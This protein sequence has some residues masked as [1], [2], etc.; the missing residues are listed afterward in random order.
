MTYGAIAL[1]RLLPTSQARL[2]EAAAAGKVQGGVEP[3][4][5]SRAAASLRTLGRDIGP[6]HARRMVAPLSAGYAVARSR[7]S[8]MDGL[9][10][11]MPT[12]RRL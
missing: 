4:D 6:D 12:H 5:L 11:V 2:E 10:V 1:E 7:R 8:D 9:D 3:Y